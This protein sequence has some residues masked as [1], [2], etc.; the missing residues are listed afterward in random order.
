VFFENQFSILERR[1]RSFDQKSMAFVNRPTALLLVVFALRA[2]GSFQKGGV[3]SPKL[4]P[5]RGVTKLSLASLKRP[6]TTQSWP[7]WQ[8]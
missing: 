6:Q 4:G 7:T 5:P 8:T 1:A 2:I 3:S